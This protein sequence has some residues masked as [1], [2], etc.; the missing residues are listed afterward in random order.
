MWEG[1]EADKDTPYNMTWVA[2]GMTNNSLILI[3]D[4]SY[5]RKKAID[6]CGEGW[7]I[8]CTKTCFRLTDTFWEKSILASTFRAE[9][10]DLC[11]LHLL[12]RGVVEYYKVK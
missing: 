5:N 11:T 6:L 8:F 1:I 10:L 3:T 9:M 12:A 2:E 7:I 4:S